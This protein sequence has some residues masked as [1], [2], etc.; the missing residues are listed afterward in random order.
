M[1]PW[2]SPSVLKANMKLS[3]ESTRDNFR[4]HKRNVIT[5]TMTKLLRIYSWLSP[6][7]VK[8]VNAHI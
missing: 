3:E 1:Y 6:S 8:A 5:V 7:A 2:L 4:N